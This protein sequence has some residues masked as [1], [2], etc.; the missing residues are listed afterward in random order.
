MLVAEAEATAVEGSVTKAVEVTAKG[1]GAK[2]VI[3]GSYA[4]AAM[5]PL[6]FRF[7]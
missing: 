5:A 6:T 1:G 7:G 4:V 2:L 3:G